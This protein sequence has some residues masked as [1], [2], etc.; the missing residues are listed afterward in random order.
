[1]AGRQEME[2]R[3]GETMQEH[4]YAEDPP[5]KCWC[6][7]LLVPVEVG[8]DQWDDRCPHGCPEEGPEEEEDGQDA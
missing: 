3:L 6:G 4:R 5:A 8:V 7:A 2:E 1:M